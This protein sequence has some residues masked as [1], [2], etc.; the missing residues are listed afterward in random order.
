[1][2]Y[3][4]FQNFH[5]RLS[6]SSFENLKFQWPSG[7]ILVCVQDAFVIESYCLPRGDRLGAKSATGSD[8]DCTWSLEMRQA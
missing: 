6:S 2:F 1:M 5:A 7:H 3:F 4:L 8:C